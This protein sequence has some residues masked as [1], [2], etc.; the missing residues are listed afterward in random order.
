MQYFMYPSVSVVNI[1]FDLCECSEYFDFGSVCR[2]MTVGSRTVRYHGPSSL[3]SMRGFSG[4]YIFFMFVLWYCLLAFSASI[5]FCRINRYIA[6][7]IEV[8]SRHFA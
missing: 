3:R 2:H 4:A 6:V 7:P 1:R 5:L 8:L